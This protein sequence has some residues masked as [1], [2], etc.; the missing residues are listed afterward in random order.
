MRPAHGH[1][2]SRGARDRRTAASH[3]TRVVTRTP[4]VWRRGKSTGRSA[5]PRIT[6]VVAALGGACVGRPDTSGARP[7]ADEPQLVAS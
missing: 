1:G 4:R 6:R 3:I 5:A 2:R 7:L